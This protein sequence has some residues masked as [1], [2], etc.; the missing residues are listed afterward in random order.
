MLSIEPS[1]YYDLENEYTLGY[2]VK[3]HCDINDF[4]KG[5]KEFEG[6]DVNPTQV[7]HGYWRFVCK[8]IV[9]A[10]KGKRGAFP[11]TYVEI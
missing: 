4:C 3:G 6:K 5:V 11:V 9:K 8:Q 1:S 10:E 2:W 7:K